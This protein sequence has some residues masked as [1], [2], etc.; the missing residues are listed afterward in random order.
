[1]PTHRTPAWSGKPKEN[2]GLLYGMKFEKG[3]LLLQYRCWELDSKP[4][5]PITI[6]RIYFTTEQIMT[7]RVLKLLEGVIFTV[8]VSLVVRLKT[9]PN[10]DTEKRTV[11][12]NNLWGR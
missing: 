10:T 9:R 11:R 12:K 3:S 5:Y 7:S 6:V 4:D 1:M 2:L 8:I